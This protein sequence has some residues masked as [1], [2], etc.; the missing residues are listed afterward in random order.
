[1]IYNRRKMKSKILKIYIKPFTPGSVK[2]KMWD[3][4]RY[5]PYDPEKWS[6]EVALPF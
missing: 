5:K 2:K 1:M 3:F 6:L 4:K